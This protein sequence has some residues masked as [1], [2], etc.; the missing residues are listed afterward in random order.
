MHR[1]AA[2]WGK[3][4]IAARA[5]VLFVSVLLTLC[6][7]ITAFYFKPV[8][9]DNS[10]EAYFLD[11]DPNLKSYD[12]LLDLFG[13]NEFLVVGIT[14]NKAGSSIITIEALQIIETITEY[15]E[16]HEHVNLVRSLTRYQHIHDENGLLTIEDMFSDLE[17]LKSTPRALS[18]L[19]PILLEEE[20]AIGSIVTTDLR[21]AR[22][23][24]RIETHKNENAHKVKLVS[25]L[26]QFIDSSD[27]QDRGFQVKLSGVPVLAERFE[28]VTSQDRALLFPI[29][30]VVITLVAY[31]L[32]KSIYAILSL[33]VVIISSSSFVLLFQSVF[34]FPNTTVNT[35]LL[36]LVIILGTGAAI[37]VLVEFREAA[38]KGMNQINAALQTCSNLFF[39]VILTSTTTAIGFLALAITDLVPVKQFSLTAAFGAMC[40]FLNTTTTLPALLS[41]LP[42]KINKDKPSASPLDNFLTKSLPKFTY[43]HRKPLWVAGLIF[44]LLSIYSISLIQV[45]TNI[46]DYFKQNSWA[47]KDLQYFN[48]HFKGINTIELIIDSGLENGIKNPEFLKRVDALQQDLEAYEQ[49]GEVLSILEFLKQIN[50]ALHNDDPSFFSL[51]SNAA[52]TA[53]LLLQYEVSG[54]TENLSDLKDFNDQYLRLSVPIINMNQIKL[55][56]FLENLDLL[57]VNNHPELNIKITGSGVLKNAQDS[58]VNSGM[59]YSFCIAI[60]MIGICFLFLFGSFKHGVVALIPSII[61]VLATGG[62]VALND[63]YLN[64][65]TMIVGATTL[66][67]AVDDSVHVMSRYRLLKFKN[68]TTLEAI[69][70]A[71]ASSGKAVIFSSL[72]L[73]LGFGTMTF[74]AFIPF[75]HFGVFSA[76]IMIFALIGD[77]LFLPALLHFVDSEPEFESDEN[78]VSY[79]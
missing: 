71:M 26:K 31:L 43:Q 12:Q 53:Q 7:L 58:Y 9:H 40:I 3:Y 6:A 10:I 28:T 79:V 25:D 61:P 32:F 52:H 42:W 30:A 65:G 59:K 1:L 72:I 16:A 14:A 47:K 41:Y 51:P 24:A 11:S 54:P 23:S 38:Q 57:F 77:L 63:I 56:G 73:V 8:R 15:L 69:S 5:W 39:P 67:I 21:H 60:L 2:Y 22:I 45:N 36:P 55:T 33:A 17:Q 76:S 18:K 29:M 68:H 27:F 48:Q 62:I 49:T 74:G 78:E 64:L 44:S 46:I 75:I 34:D 66:G 35:A 19:R 13:D 70:G 20:L 4:I 37:H 50:Q